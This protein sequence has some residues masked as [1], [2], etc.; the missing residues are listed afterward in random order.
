MRF[1][2]IVTLGLGALWQQK[3]RTILTTLGVVFGTFVLVT[4]LSINDGVQETII[5][6]YSR[7]GELRF[8][9][10]RGECQHR[11][12]EKLDVVCRRARSRCP[13]EVTSA[14]LGRA[15]IGVLVFTTW[16]R[17]G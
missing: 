7:H 13:R 9:R 6:E 5:R 8:C 2:D 15:L 10:V 14:R 4:S 1:R 17:H 12:F 16:G 11:A 3:V